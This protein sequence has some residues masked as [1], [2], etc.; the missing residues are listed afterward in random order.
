MSLVVGEEIRVAHQ[1]RPVLDGV[2][3]SVDT[4]LTGLLGV[5]GAG[6]ST[7]LRALAGVVPPSGGSVRIG[8]HDPYAAASRPAALRLLG[9]VPQHLEAPPAFS[10]ADYLL[11]LC[12][13]KEVPR[14]ERPDAV[15]RALAAVDLTDRASARLSTL[16]GGMRQRASIAQALLTDP[17]VLLLDEPTT[18]LDPHQRAELRGL[19]QRLGA[20]RAVLLATHIVED[21]E[22]VADHLVVLHEGRV[23][24]D[25]PT[26]ELAAGADAV[27]AG[28]AGADGAVG[29]VGAVGGRLERGF[30]GLVVGA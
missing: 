27:D 15:G 24:F 18:G 11:H 30:L 28:G 5:N 26:A 10:V 6:K 8:G 19:V 13:L 9:Y 21:V 17:R 29:A 1:G 23:R 7:L 25:G 20:D 4:G 14:R 3:F 2:T 12:W 22:Y 16:S